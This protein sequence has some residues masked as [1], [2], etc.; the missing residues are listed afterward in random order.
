[1]KK[2]KQSSTN[3]VVDECVTQTDK[4]YVVLHRAAY[5][6]M[7]RE[8]HLAMGHDA[9]TK[10]I[11]SFL[12]DAAVKLRQRLIREEA[13]ETIAALAVNPVNLI[14]LADG[15]CD[16][17]YVT[18]GAAVVAGHQDL[19]YSNDLQLSL[20]DDVYAAWNAICNILGGSVS[21]IEAIEK[22]SC[23]S[24]GKAGVLARLINHCERIAAIYGIPLKDCFEEVHKSNMTKLGP[25]G[26]PIYHTD[27]KI[28]KGPN[29][30]KP[31]LTSI[32]KK[33]GV[34]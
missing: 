15:L 23:H 20:V 24:W 3:Q 22:S 2:T 26:K 33:Y 10:I 13:R 6:P 18:A 17:I 29:F 4:Y 30:K 27:G 5:V 7:V 16:L 1:M 14:E 9:P 28:A 8:F 34:V 31:D 19:T 11:D 32:L 12:D 25:D 21:A